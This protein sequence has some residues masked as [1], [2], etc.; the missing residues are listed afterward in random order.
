ME[1]ITLLEQMEIKKTSEKGK[2]KV[3]NREASNLNNS[4]PCHLYII[5]VNKNE[6]R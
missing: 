5:G 3:T 4:S 6:Q 2:E 1:R